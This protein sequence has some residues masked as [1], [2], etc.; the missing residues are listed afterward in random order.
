MRIITLED[1]FETAL[2]ADLMPPN[3][4]RLKWYRD[5]SKHL[6][7]DMPKELKDL[8]ASRIAAMDA[9]GIDLQVLSLT[10]PGVQGFEGEMALRIAR[11]ANEKMADA[12]AAYPGRFASFAALPTSEPEA[13][14][15]ELEHWVRQGFLG[16]MINSHTKGSFLDDK[17]YWP[18]FAKAVELDVPI[19]LHPGQPHPLLMQSY[20][21]GFEDLARPAWGFQADASM[22]FLRLLFSG[23]FDEYPTLQIILGH[24]GESIPFAMDRLLDH[25][26][27][28]A[29]WRG[30][31][32]KPAECLRE[33][34][35]ITTS[36][37]FSV[38]SMLCTIQMMGIDKVLFSVDWPYE[39]NLVGVNWFH[40]LPLSQD[41]KEKIAFR[42]AER[43][44]RLA[45]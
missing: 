45:K 27:Y 15:A 35:I 30:M 41:D 31:K 40:S 3:E 8:G 7:H 22:H 16:A 21:L 44:L 13:A 24:L 17:K 14:A 39:S 1:H 26:G 19:Y 20:F 18:I 4:L 25:T 11:D 36:G 6:G 32:R 34:L 10:S 33:N 43:V 29:E 28:V 2:Y 23:V 12:V 42:N 5:R 38:P 37:N 9:A